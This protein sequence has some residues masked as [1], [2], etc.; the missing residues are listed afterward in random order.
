MDHFHVP[1]QSGCDTTLKEMKRK[2][3]RSE[4]LEKLEAIRSYFPN[5][6]IGADIITGFPGETLQDHQSSMKFVEES[7]LT[8]FHVF[9]YSKRKGTLAARREDHLPVIEKK[10]RCLEMIELGKIEH[11]KFLAS[12]IDRKASVLFEKRPKKGHY[13][14]YTSNFARVAIPEEPQFVPGIHEVLIKS[15]EADHLLSETSR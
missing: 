14:G 4:Y 12:Q 1:L 15:S 11:G 13:W 10:R 8:H 9:P 7:P 6:G 2:Y 3:S 5:S